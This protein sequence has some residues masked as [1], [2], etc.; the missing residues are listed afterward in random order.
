[1][2]NYP[3]GV[4]DSSPYFNPSTCDNC[5]E[6]AAPGEDCPS[7]GEYVYTPEDLQDMKADMDYD[8]LRDEGY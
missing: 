7:C 3:P 5:G 4:S 1:M 6:E 2:S 8:R